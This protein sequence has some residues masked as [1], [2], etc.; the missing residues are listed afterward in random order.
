MG[1]GWAIIDTGGRLHIDDEMMKELEEV[2]KAVSPT[3]VLLVVDAMTGQD[4][5]TSAQEF[6]QKVSIT[7]LIMTKLDGDARGGAAI[8]I[9][10]V[11][12]VP[13]K[14]IGVGERTDSPRSPSTPTGW[15]LGSWAWAMSC[16]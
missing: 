3:E 8:S 16:P 10:Q 7:G 11:T 6:H 4:A 15:P 5:V 14:F 9:T 1:L 2:K 12:G 13:I